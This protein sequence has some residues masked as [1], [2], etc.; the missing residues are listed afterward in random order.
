M[1]KSPSPAPC[2]EG[3][4]PKK[5][6][7][8]S[9][10]G[11]NGTAVAALLLLVAALFGRTVGFGYVSYDD[12]LY[13][14]ANGIV[15]GGLSLASLSWSFTTLYLSNWH[16]LTW[17]SHLLDVSLFGVEPAG[18]HAVNVLLHGANAVLLFLFLRKATGAPGKSLLVAALFA[19]HP[20]HVE[21][22]AWVSER[23]GLLSTLFWLS[24]SLAW[25]R[26][27]AAP[28]ARRYGAA[29]LLFALSLLAKP[30]AV[31]FPLVLLLLDFWP[32]G[33]LR[34]VPAAR[35]LAE[36]APL[37]VLSALSAAVT[38]WAQY[39]GGSVAPLGMISPLSR[40]ANAPLALAGYLSK[41]FLPRGL[42]VFYRHP[43]ESVSLAVAAL[44]ALA[45]AALTTVAVRFRKE[46][47]WLLFGWLFFLVTLLP[48][49]GIVQ[50]GV[51][52]MADRYS[53]VPLVGILVAVAWEGEGIA[54]RLCGDGERQR[55]GRS[56][57]AAAVVAVLSA[58]AW[59]RVSDWR[60]DETLFTA[61]LAEDPANYVAHFNLGTLLADRGDA[62]GAAA[63]YLEAIRVRPRYPDPHNNLANL[64][65]DRGD[66]AGALFHYREALRLR[67]GYADAHFNLAGLLVS[68]GRPG[69][70]IPHYEAILRTSPRDVEALFGL[71]NARAAGGEWGLAAAAYR[72]ALAVEPRNGTV[73][74]ALERALAEAGRPAAR[75]AAG[76]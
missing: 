42:S 7:P 30:M 25:L 1:K 9:P 14:Y 75:G 49:L 51:Q 70:A 32:L 73:R 3:G 76:R 47:P 26:Y 23:K 15:R 57:F 72:D 53:Y 48:V 74:L 45:L 33:R 69:E 29:A 66:V 62:N 27:A 11:G 17:I 43:E 56:A 8:L 71:G 20:L 37:L 50:V 58:T 5:D 65:H 52:A 18:H 36:K 41:T 60:N 4:K 16:P 55:K 46:R 31:T 13:V 22:V 61:A 10:A 34:V 59:G 24:A 40:A 6:T 68:V 21:S 67:P 28:S 2:P 63:H 19:V 54:R 35:L 38:S 44:A 39:A 64:L 12:N